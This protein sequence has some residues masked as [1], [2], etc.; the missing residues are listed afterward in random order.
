VKTS[1]IAF[2]VLA[3]ILMHQVVSTRSFSSSSRILRE[4]RELG[5]TWILQ[6]I[7]IQQW[8][9]A[10]IDGLRENYGGR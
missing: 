10:S 9:N 4:W 2:P 3:S 7:T 1:L 8:R 5:E 6:S